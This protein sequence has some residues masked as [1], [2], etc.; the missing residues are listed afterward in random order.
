MPQARLPDIN[1]QYIKFTNEAVNSWKSENYEAC[2][3]SLFTL[4]AL[5]PEKYRVV[6][7]NQEHKKLTNEQLW[8]ICTKCKHEN[9]HED[10]K[11]Y[12]LMMPYIDSVLTKTKYQEMWRCTEC[13]K[14]NILLKSDMVQDKPKDPSYFKVV[15]EPPSQK[16]GIMDRR[17]YSTK[18]TLWFWTCLGEIESQ[19]ATFRDD[20]W[21]KNELYQDLDY[22]GSEEAEDA[23]A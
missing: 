16:D 10:I 3:G 21:T 23:T 11:Y 1:T 7:S 5:M 12:Q 14:E 17:K 20:N 18:F 13:K 2:L 6:I 8:N 4:N 9:K 19:M 22:D 15:P